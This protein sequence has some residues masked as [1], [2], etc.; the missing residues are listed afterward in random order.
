MENYYQVLGVYPS[1]SMGQIER[2]FREQADRVRSKKDYEKLHKAY[3]ILSDYHQRRRY[4][5]HLERHQERSL[6]PKESYPMPERRISTYDDM[7][8]MFNPFG[9]ME[10]SHKQ[11]TDDPFYQ[12]PKSGLQNGQ[13]SYSMSYSSILGPDG[14]KKVQK[15]VCQNVDGKK[16]C[17]VWKEDPEK[18]RVDIDRNGQKRQLVH[19]KKR[20]K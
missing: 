8:G 7:F 2:A 5:D 19:R 9:M 20:H 4:D 15:S 1:A 6:V 13:Q 12:M 11:F 17:K 18:I 16:S 10:R 14:K 3:T